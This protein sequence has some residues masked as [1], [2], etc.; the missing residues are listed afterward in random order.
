VQTYFIDPLSQGLPRIE[1]YSQKS[2]HHSRQAEGVRS[3]LE[4]ARQELQQSMLEA[5]ETVDFSQ[6]QQEQQELETISQRLMRFLT[7]KAAVD[8]LLNTLR[9][10]RSALQDQLQCV[11]LQTPIYERVDEHLERTVEQLESDLRNARVV[12]ESTTIFQDIQR[13]VESSRLER[14][15]F[16]MGASAGLLAGIFTFNS[17]LDIWSLALD[18]SG[19][20]LPPVWLRILLGFIAGVS[21][22]LAAT[23]IVARRKRHAALAI[24]IGLSTIVLAI[25]TTIIANR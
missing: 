18:G 15:S 4:A 17:F 23:W 1:L 3:S 14:A 5:M 11:R 13:G 16:L 12:A 22:P 6:L 25:I 24:V 8:V 9:N 20:T 2:L 10:N 21:L 19:L 7:Q